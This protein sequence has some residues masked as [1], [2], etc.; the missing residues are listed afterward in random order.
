MEA[1]KG[2]ATEDIAIHREYL[3]YYALARLRDLDEAE[4]AV[5]ETFL[6]ALAGDRT[7]SG[8]S[9]RRT[10]LTGILNHKVCDLQRQRFRNRSLFQ[11]LSL[12]NGQEWDPVT[13]AS[14]RQHSSD[15]RMELEYKELREALIEAMRKLPPRMALVYRLFESEARGS[16]EI[17]ESLRISPHN[18]WVIL[19]RARKRLR[20]S[21]S[22]WW[23]TH[24][25]RS[26]DRLT[27][28][29]M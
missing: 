23:S 11:S 17:C 6:A 28:D 24:R 29:T 22:S 13:L 7:F 26:G 15:P 3:F 18:L 8:N 21:L 16:R 19:H 14:M 2:A 4:D 12:D 27:E 20:E 10:W 5:Q 9:T 25:T 1:S